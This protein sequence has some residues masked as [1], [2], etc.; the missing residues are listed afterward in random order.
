[1]KLSPWYYLLKT[2]NVNIPWYE[3]TQAYLTSDILMFI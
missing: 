3:C 1:M 2:H